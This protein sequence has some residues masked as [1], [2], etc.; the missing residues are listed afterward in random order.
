MR[1]TAITVD[2]THG[3]ATIYTGDSRIYRSVLRRI[4]EEAHDLIRTEENPEVGTYW[5][6]LPA[7]FLRSTKLFLYSTNKIRDM[8]E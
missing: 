7:E 3:E 4:P 5:I 6:W 2:H 1:E 8:I